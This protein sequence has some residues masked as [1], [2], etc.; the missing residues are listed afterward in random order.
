MISK[1]ETIQQVLERVKI[2]LKKYK[3]VPESYLAR[4]PAVYK[5]SGLEPDQFT[6]L[7]HS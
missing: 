4:Q 1:N 6:A 3:A 7:L 5:L 2:T